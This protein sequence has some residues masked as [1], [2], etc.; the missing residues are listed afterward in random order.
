MPH[1]RNKPRS[2]NNVLLAVAFLVLE[3]HSYISGISTKY[4]AVSN[5]MF[6]AHGG[7]KGYLKRS[8]CPLQA[9]DLLSPGR[10][11]HFV[12]GTKAKSRKPKRRVSK[13]SRK[14]QS[15]QSSTRYNLRSKGSAAA[16]EPEDVDP[17]EPV[18][19]AIMRYVAEDGPTI[20]R[21]RREWQEAIRNAPK[22]LVFNE[23]DQ[24]NPSVLKEYGDQLPMKWG[25][26][27]WPPWELW[28]DKNSM[29]YTFWMHTQTNDRR[30]SILLQ[31]QD[32]GG[33][34]WPS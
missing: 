10:R 33:Q 22:F 21:Q 4:E 27:S 29:Y 31:H 7:T 17:N 30:S 1:P 14:A 28:M 20:E 23:E 18:Y 3:S 12:M 32:E 11:G 26:N 24:G 13:V 15:S 9:L 34:I 2:P 25:D 6:N 19:V 8:L 5:W 16:E